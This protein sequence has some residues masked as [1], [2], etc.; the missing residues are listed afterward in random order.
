MGRLFAMGGVAIVVLAAAI[1]NAAELV[2]I[3][4]SIGLKLVAIPAGKFTMG[5]PTGEKNRL[6]NEKQVAVTITKPFLMGQTEVTQGQWKA[7]MGTEPWKGKDNTME[8][9]NHPASFMS[10]DDATAFCEKLTAMEKESG[11][12]EAG[13][14]YLLPTEA[15]WEYAC[16]AGTTTAFWGDEAQ[17]STYAWWGGLIGSGNAQ[18]EQYAHEVATKKPNAWG[19]YDMRGNCWEWCNDYY[20]NKL[21]GGNDPKGPTAGSARVIRGGSWSLS[22]FLCRSAYRQ[23]YAPTPRSDDDGFRVV[24]LS[25][26]TDTAAAEKFGPPAR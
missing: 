5:S 3:E 20:S 22:A 2:V 8:G 26:A 24:R 13:E 1:T 4:N 6:A 9:T 16:R 14:R 15:Q 7:V 19:L 23:N 18:N 25:E 11:K 12:I 10:W 17:L 21:S